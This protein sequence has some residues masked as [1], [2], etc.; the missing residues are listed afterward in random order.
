MCVFCHALP[1]QIFDKLFIFP[2]SVTSGSSV[3]GCKCLAYIK[4]ELGSVFT[5]CPGDDGRISHSCTR[6]MSKTGF[7]HSR[8]KKVLSAQL[9]TW[10]HMGITCQKCWISNRMQNWIELNLCG[11]F[12]FFFYTH[13]WTQFTL[14]TVVVDKKQQ[15]SLY[16]LFYLWSWRVSFCVITI[17]FYQLV[18]SL[19]LC[20]YLPLMQCSWLTKTNFPV[21]WVR[22][23]PCP[24]FCSSFEGRFVLTQPRC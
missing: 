7:T 1:W 12:F 21:L 16:L 19:T 9:E 18:P 6:H 15:V 23:S 14:D 24:C 5:E 3:R 2:A 8:T 4:C 17:F 20:V 13:V 22:L 11:L 10:N